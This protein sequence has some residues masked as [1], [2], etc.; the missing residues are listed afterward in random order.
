MA[1]EEM[2][3]VNHRHQSF[4]RRKYKVKPELQYTR[5][6][7]LEAIL[8]QPKVGFLSLDSPHDLPRWISQH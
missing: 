1:E 2:S 8:S 4:K 5:A 7:E 3:K 6:S